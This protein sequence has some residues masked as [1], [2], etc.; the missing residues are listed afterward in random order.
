MIFA[1]VGTHH[2]PFDRLVDAVAGVHDQE[3][4]IQYGHSSRPVAVERA[5]PFMSFSEM[6]RLMG[7]A[8]V[9]VTHAGVGSVLLAL[10]HGHVPLVMVRLRRNGE[11]VDDHQAELATALA[12]RGE[13]I[14]VDNARQL[15]DAVSDPPP[16]RPPGNLEKRPLHRAVRAALLD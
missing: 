9:V 4:V 15:R 1:T 3:V 10:R 14:L 8:D 6:E 12:Q 13:V 5:E 2:Q 16:R 11:H 7:E